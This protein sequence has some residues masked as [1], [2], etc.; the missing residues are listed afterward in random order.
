MHARDAKMTSVRT[1]I[2]IDENVYRQAK[3]R[4][5]T[6]GRT[7]S[8]IIE[9]AVRESLRPRPTDHTELPPLPTFGGS[10]VL[11]GVD[12]ADASALRDRM[13]EGVPLHAL[14]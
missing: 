7:V 14:R 10:G 12:L 11:P 6:T 4:A 3:S 2:R 8:E 13:D 9:D 5:A 1:T